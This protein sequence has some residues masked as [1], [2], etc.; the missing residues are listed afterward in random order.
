M[1]RGRWLSQGKLL[2]FIPKVESTNQCSCPVKRMST[3]FLSKSPIYSTSR[4]TPA[5]CATQGRCFLRSIYYVLLPPQTISLEEEMG[6]FHIYIC[7]SILTS[8]DFL[9]YR[10]HMRELIPFLESPNP[11]QKKDWGARG[12]IFLHR[13]L[14]HPGAVSHPRGCS[15]SP[16]I[17]SLLVAASDLCSRSHFPPQ[18][19]QSE[20]Q[21]QTKTQILFLELEGK[22]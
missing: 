9:S 17:L 3:Y 6:Y 8:L 11:M 5:Y 16:R 22:S 15:P 4:E 12:P 20:T 19:P 13:A 21:S 18:S 10:L 7:P 2:I 14:T 1:L